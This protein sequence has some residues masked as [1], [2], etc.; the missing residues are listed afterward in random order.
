MTSSV[1]ME[2]C[3]GSSRMWA[4]LREDG[5]IQRASCGDYVLTREGGAWVGARDGEI[6][7]RGSLSK[8]AVDCVGPRS[9]K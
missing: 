6:L 7:S 3:L 4:L 5:R 9:E 8:V 1:I 2:S